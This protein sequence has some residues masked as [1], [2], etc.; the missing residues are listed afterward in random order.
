ME[1]DVAIPTYNRNDYMRRLLG[2]IPSHVTVYVS[3][4]GHFV[5]DDIKEEFPN[6]TFLHQDKVLDV[7]DNWNA[8]SKKIGAKW[9]VIPSDDDL[10]YTG[11][12]KII[13][14]YTEKFPSADILIFGYHVIDEND[15]VTGTWRPSEEQV[16]QPPHGYFKFKYGVDARMPAVVFKTEMLKR[17]TYFDGNFKLTAGDSDLIQRC[18]LSGQAVFIPETI[19]AYRVWSGG[20]TSKKISSTQ[21][22]QEIDYWQQKIVKI[23]NSSVDYTSLPTGPEYP[24]PT[25][26]RDEVYAQNLL[27][28]LVS[29][30]ENGSFI[31]RL[32][33][34][35]DNRFPWKSRFK[36]QVKLLSR[37]F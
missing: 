5:T 32:R 30:K 24:A 23:L 10:F 17:M 29:L 14:K 27:A 35:T 15:Q 22:L 8:C 37:I 18:L 21:W 25:S 2:T 20:L 7:F 31:Q 6:A 9:A 13:E 28:G 34:L 16:F 33:F 4:N 26:I 12:F 11:A 3:D 1:I 19:G 36:T